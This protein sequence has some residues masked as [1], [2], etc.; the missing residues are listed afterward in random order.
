MACA[1]CTNIEC[2]DLYVNPCD[3]GVDTG[4]VLDESG[5]YT[6]RIEFNGMV[7]EI[8]LEVTADEAIVLPNSMNLNYIHNL[9]IYDDSGVLVEDTCYR[10]KMHLSLGLAN[11]ITP[12]PEAGT[13]KLIIVDIDGTEFTNSFFATHTILAISTDSQTYLK[14]VGFTQSGNTITAIQFAF[15]NGQTIFAQA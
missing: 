7:N 11:N 10:L 14:D 15:Y 3:T 1:E 13:S 8:V 9:T 2:I 6:F 4:I 12:T 5:N